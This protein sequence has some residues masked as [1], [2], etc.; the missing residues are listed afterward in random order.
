MKKLHVSV[1]ITVFNEQST[2]DKLINSLKNQS[3][4]PYEVIMVD[5]GSTDKTFDILKSWSHK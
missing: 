3:L 2:L 4:S 1:V 5:G